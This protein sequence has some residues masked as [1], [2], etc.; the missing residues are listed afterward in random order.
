MKTLGLSTRAQRRALTFKSAALLALLL[1][2]CSGVGTGGTG[3]YVDGTVDGFGSVFAADIE[4]DDRGAAVLDDDGAPLLR[5]GNEL[6]L[7]MTVEIDGS[8]PVDTASGRT[9]IASTIRIATAVTGPVE[10]V[11]ARNRVLTVLGQR[12]EITAATVLDPTLRGGLPALRPGEIVTAYALADAGSGQYIAT[13]IDAAP[14]A[15]IYRLR[16]LVDA[17]D[18]VAKTLRIGGASLDYSRAAGVPVGLADGQLIRARIRAPAGSG[19]LIVEA[20]AG[21]TAAPDEADAA[22]VEGPATSVDSRGT[23]RV[24]GLRVDASQARIS[25][26]GAAIGPGTY[27]KVQGRTQAGTVIANTVTVLTRADVGTRMYQLRGP[28]GSLDTAAAT[29]ALRGMVVDYSAASFANGTAANLANGAALR[30]MGRL[31]SDGTRIGATRITF[32]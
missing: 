11:D 5:D 9:S 7:G 25:P 10:S 23:M 27:L 20:L 16:G 24:N 2:G 14:A 21:A 4:F 12:L 28:I 1:I 29:F 3:A 6:R 22:F 19:P 18:P 13:R 8:T 26:A 31:S 15:R 32:Q 17:L 30:V